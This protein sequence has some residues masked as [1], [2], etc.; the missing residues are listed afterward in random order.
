MEE[1]RGGEGKVRG[2]GKE[3]KGKEGGKEPRQR[4]VVGATPFLE[5]PAEG[6]RAYRNGGRGGISRSPHDLFRPGGTCASQPLMAAITLPTHWC[7]N[8]EKK[9]KSV[10]S[11]KINI[12]L[13]AVRNFTCPVNDFQT[14][15]KIPLFCG[16]N[17]MSRVWTFYGPPLYDFL[18]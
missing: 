16:H 18:G 10:A 1:V 2:G 17:P 15:R 6:W 13:T 14:E 7:L 12:R 4:A 9:D 5:L 11:R 8:P 3:E